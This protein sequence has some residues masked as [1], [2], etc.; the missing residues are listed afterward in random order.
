MISGPVRDHLRRQVRVCHPGRRPVRPSVGCCV[1]DPMAH[2]WRQASGGPPWSIPAIVEG[3]VVVEV[4]TGA[5]KIIP[6]HDFN[7]WRIVMCIFAQHVR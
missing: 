5:L 4:G 3:H 1:L 6:S 7:D 2:V